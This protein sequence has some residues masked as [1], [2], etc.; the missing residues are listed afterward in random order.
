ME[1]IFRKNLMETIFRKNLMKLYVLSNLWCLSMVH[2]LF[3]TLQNIRGLL[4]SYAWLQYGTNRWRVK[5]RHRAKADSSRQSEAKE[6]KACSERR[7]GWGFHSE[8]L[9]M[10]AP[11]RNQ[12]RADSSR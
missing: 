3:T 10:G 1:T 6:R 5:P 2:V 4:A 8:S 9:S 11:G 12:A 7:R